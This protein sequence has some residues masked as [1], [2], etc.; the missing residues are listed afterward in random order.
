MTCIEQMTCALYLFWSSTG[1]VQ[2]NTGVVLCSSTR[3]VFGSSTGV[4]Q[5]SAGVLLC[6]STGVVFWSSILK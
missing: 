5:S 1:V 6:S 2:S 4:V 3:V